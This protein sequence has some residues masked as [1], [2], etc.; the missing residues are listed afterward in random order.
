MTGVDADFKMPM[1]SY[2]EDMP[3]DLAMVL[4]ASQVMS[5]LEGHTPFLTIS[6]L[7]N[8][9]LKLHGELNPAPGPKWKLS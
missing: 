7:Q 1:N 8:L 6:S 4:V 9:E 5:W 2:F 3:G